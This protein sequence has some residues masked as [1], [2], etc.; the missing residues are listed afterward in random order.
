[1]ST[2]RIKIWMNQSYRAHLFVFVELHPDLGSRFHHSSLSRD[3]SYGYPAWYHV[4]R[5]RISRIL[6][7]KR[8][9]CTYFSWVYG[10]EFM[11]STKRSLLLISFLFFFLLLIFNPWLGKDRSCSGTERHLF[12]VLMSHFS[13]FSSGNW[14]HSISSQTPTTAL[15]FLLPNW[16]GY[17]SHVSLAFC[18]RLVFFARKRAKMELWG[19]G[20]P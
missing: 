18:L 12:W 9:L 20:Y 11:S 2:I 5:L 4:T 14:C 19:S 7:T 15:N 10:T 6:C 8:H 17:L 3:L 1:M 16:I 13:T